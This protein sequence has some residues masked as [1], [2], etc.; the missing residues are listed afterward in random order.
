MNDK[1]YH[2]KE[3]FLMEKLKGN[4]VWMDRSLFWPDIMVVEKC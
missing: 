3:K 4:D 1:V 2:S